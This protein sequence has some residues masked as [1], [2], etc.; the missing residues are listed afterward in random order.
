MDLKKASKPSPQG[1]KKKW[2]SKGPLPQGKRN[3]TN[4]HWSYTIM[5]VGF[6]VGLFLI[7]LLAPKTLISTYQLIRVYLFCALVL[8]LI[9]LKWWNTFLQ[10]ERFESVLLNIM[11]LGPALTA[12]LLSINYL[13]ANPQQT[14]TCTV[15]HFDMGRTVLTGN[16]ITLELDCPALDDFPEARRFD[17][18]AQPEAIQ[19][20]KAVF[21]LRKGMLG[22]K[23]VRGVEF[24]LE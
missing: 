2:G 6:F 13:G 16:H 12:L 20:Q 3:N 10:L 22:Y 11:G 5:I 17:I 23:V 9:P 1:Y 7:L 15:T 8:L 4:W 18:Y 24:V 14:L 21:D 19:A